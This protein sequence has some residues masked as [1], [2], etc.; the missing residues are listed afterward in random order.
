MRQ[1]SYRI[2]T[3]KHPERLEY[4]ILDRNDDIWVIL[5]KGDNILMGYCIEMTES[6]FAIKKENFDK[7]L[8][9]LKAVFIPENMTCY[10]YIGDKQ[11]PHF[12]WVNTKPVL[13]STKIGSALE[14]IRYIP[15]Y[16]D[17]GDICDVEF[18]GEKSGDEKV[19]FKALAPYV[20]SGSYLCFKGEDENTWKWIFDNGKVKCI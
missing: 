10:N 8:Q 14:E 12:S 13:E 18:T 2:K 11:N 3:K 7:A 5:L 15:T 4:A 16:N 1:I 17:N 9:A 6:K 20:E 19:F